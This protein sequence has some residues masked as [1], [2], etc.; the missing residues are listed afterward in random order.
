MIE[1]PA[2]TSFSRHRSTHIVQDHWSDVAFE[3]QAWDICKKGFSELVV[4][5]FVFIRLPS[6]LASLITLWGRIGYDSLWQE[7][8]IP[9]FP[10][11]VENGV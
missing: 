6:T 9:H 1:R 11:T 10:A 3:L 4:C 2:F 7:R 8:G 5:F